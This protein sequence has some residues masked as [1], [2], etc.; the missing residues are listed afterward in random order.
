MDIPQDFDDEYYSYIDNN[1]IEIDN[2]FRL[3]HMRKLTD[4]DIANHIKEINNN[5]T[6]VNFDKI[7]PISHR[8]PW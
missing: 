2:G 8:N 4:K 5:V 3:T 7:Y 1:Y 6:R